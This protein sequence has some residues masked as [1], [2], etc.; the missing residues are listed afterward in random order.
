MLWDPIDRGLWGIAISILL[1]AAIS[2]L[3]KGKKRENSNERIV[4]Y[5]FAVYL[6]LSAIYFIILYVLE[7][8]KPGLF[9]NG[10]FYGD[11]DIL[12]TGTTKLLF[13]ASNVLFLASHFLLLLAIERVLNLT[14]YLISLLNFIIIVITIVF[15]SIATYGVNGSTNIFMDIVFLLLEVFRYIRFVFLLIVCYYATKWAQLEFKSVT[16]F[17]FLGYILI[18]W[19]AELAT[20]YKSI[21]LIPLFLP[22]IITIIGTLS[23]IIPQ[24]IPHR[25]L[26]KGLTMWK[27]I[28]TT[29]IAFSVARDLFFIFIGVWAFNYNIIFGNITIS[30]IMYAIIQHIFTELSLKPK[31]PKRV[32]R[33]ILLW[34]II[35][36]L[37]ICSYLSITIYL[38]SREISLTYPTVTYNSLAYFLA[39]YIIIKNIK[40]ERI[41]ETK[42][43]FKEILGIFIK[44][45]KLTEEE[46]TFH[47]EQKICL[48]CKGKV[49]GF[50]SFICKC[51]ALYCE[52]C[53]QTLSDLENACWV[54]EAPFDEL[55]PV[56]LYKEK[57]LDDITVEKPHKKK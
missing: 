25:Y 21:G 36:V 39:I 10:N 24:L 45:E 46:I 20:G 49:L 32:S 23:F 28:G 2:Y 34:K 9:I 35:G 11:Y 12:S 18:Q 56:K 5:G 48:V 38:I 1:F 41:A 53:A 7:I 43:E 19:G 47:K 52:K 27:I 33:F 16:G 3:N 40:T 26:S 44:P 55:K 37:L 54:C 4:M 15:L 22:P 30:L 50:N 8:S 31:D 29:I 6:V 13:I 51:D 17:L 14:K 57:E 42:G